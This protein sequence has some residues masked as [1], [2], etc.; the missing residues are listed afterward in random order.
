MQRGEQEETETAAEFWVFFLSRFDWPF[1]NASFKLQRRGN[2]FPRLQ[3]TKEKKKKLR[4][5]SR[6]AINMEG[7]ENVPEYD[8]VGKVLNTQTW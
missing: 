3:I 7:P 2:D 5:S 8:T 6:H 1:Q 4:R